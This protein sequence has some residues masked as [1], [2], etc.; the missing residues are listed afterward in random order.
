MKYIT[1]KMVAEK[2]EVSVYC[3]YLDIF[4]ISTYNH[5]GDVCINKIFYIIISIL[6]WSDK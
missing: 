5:E 3:I 4:K 2:A 1:L 6:N